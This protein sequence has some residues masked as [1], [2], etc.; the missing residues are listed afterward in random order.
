M[1]VGHRESR[2]MTEAFGKDERRDDETRPNLPASLLRQI[3][4][5]SLVD[6]IFF[7]MQLACHLGYYTKKDLTVYGKS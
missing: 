4:T 6:N 2:I 7:K 3:T 5:L 1:D